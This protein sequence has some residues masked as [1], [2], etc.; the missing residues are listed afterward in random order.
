[1]TTE[2]EGPIAAAKQA[3]KAQMYTEAL[4][5]AT[6]AVTRYQRETEA[7][8]L[9]SFVFA[10]AGSYEEAVADF[11]TA[12][13]IDPT[14]VY[15]FLDRGHYHLELGSGARPSPI[16]AAASTC[17]MRMIARRSFSCALRDCCS[18]AERRRRSRIP[19][20]SQ[21]MPNSGL[22]ASYGRSMSS[23]SASSRSEGSLRS[24]SARLT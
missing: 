13:S 14:E 15:L 18:S 21:T 8:R 22:T 24:D 1:M 3:A 20:I 12:I 11:S 5:V 6:E 7:W 9:R 23:L 16:L 4:S 2:L 10:L 17:A 19:P